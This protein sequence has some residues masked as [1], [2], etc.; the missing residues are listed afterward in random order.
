MTPR[1]PHLDDLAGVIAGFAHRLAPPPAENT[2]ADLV[3]YESLSLD[4]LFPAPARVPIVNVKR[5]WRALGLESALAWFPSQH[6][7]I[8]PRFARR[9]ARHRSNHTVWTRWLRPDGAEGRPRLVYLHG[10]MQPETMIEEVGLL[11]Q[12]ATQL[13]VEVVQVQPP[14]HGRRKPR[15]SRF[16]GDHFFTA[17]IVRSIEAL[18]QSILDVRSV[19]SWL[20]DQN[21]RPVGVMGLSL[22][23]ALS[24]ALT[25]L[26]PRFA[27]SA[28]LIAHM[29]VAATFADAPVLEPVRRELSAMGF[30]PQDLARF[31]ERVGWNALTAR[32]APSRIQLLCA[33]DDHFFRRELV[34]AMWRRWGE[35]PIHWYP[36]SH[37]GFLPHIPDAI[38]RVRTLVDRVHRETQCA[39]PDTAGAK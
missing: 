33:S 34:D 14:Y 29:D 16:D 11:T 10:F 37:M 30:D 31:F 22:G 28:P 24:A 36:C 2:I 1:G 6:E 9:Y 39:L 21:D 15:R 26:E 32:I 25:C 18:R 20:L 35:P 7:P 27:F 8:E 17:D 23:G 4:E 38:A 3:A 13:D 5:R 12:L 19:L